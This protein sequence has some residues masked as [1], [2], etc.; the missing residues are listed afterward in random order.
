[1]R[2]AYKQQQKATNDRLLAGLRNLFALTIFATVLSIPLLVGQGQRKAAPCTYI[3]EYVRT[4]TPAR[5]SDV[6]PITGGVLD[7]CGSRAVV[8]V[9][10]IMDG[11]V[12]VS[13]TVIGIESQLSRTTPVR[14][15]YGEAVRFGN[16]GVYIEISARKGACPG[17]ATLEIAR[18]VSIR[19]ETEADRTGGCLRA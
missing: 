9:D 12:E 2:L 15:R 5:A 10:R 11:C 17:C 14:L 18:P 4:S 7:L 16:L 3:I 6:I 8:S 19:K 1:M 13:V